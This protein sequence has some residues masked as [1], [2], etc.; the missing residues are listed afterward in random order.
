MTTNRKAAVILLVFSAFWAIQTYNLPGTT[1][2]GTPGPRFFPWILVISLTVLSVFLYLKGGK[3]ASSDGENQNDNSN[4]R[5]PF[6]QGFKVF[7]TILLYVFLVKYLG[8][9]IG[10]ILGL[11]FVLSLNPESNWKSTLI[12]ACLT[13]VVLHLVFKVLLKIPLPTGVLF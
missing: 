4:K 2:E 1:M 5:E 7:L 3:Q 10:T 6:F 12:T 13:G 9:M 8:F 11:V